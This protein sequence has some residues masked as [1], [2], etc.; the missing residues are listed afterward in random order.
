MTRTDEYRATLRALPDRDWDEYLCDRSGLPGPRGN[1]E[2][3]V[4]AAEEA[5][6]SRIRGW[7]EWDADRAPANTPAELLTFCGVLGLGRLVVEGDDQALVVLRRHASDPRWRTRE[8]V[9]MA[10]QRIADADF[11]RA[12]EIVSEWVRGG[13][14]ERRAAA[15]GL[16]EPRLLSSRDRT[17]AVLDLLDAIT[18]KVVSA[19]RDDRRHVDFRALRK[20]LGY[21]WSVAVASDPTTGTARM[22]RWIGVEDEDVRWLMRTN[23][24][25][26]RLERMD[27][28]WVA[29]QRSRLTWA[30]SSNP[31]AP[32]CG[33]VGTLGPFGPS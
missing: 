17:A 4:A 3:A 1:I 26:R 27:S 22:E 28:A 24:T 6:P 30:S 20:A 11:D 23:L 31:P 13:W 14:L 25:K 32:D 19:E 7:L 9:A 8:A 10:I 12:L 21:C 5:S 2:L 16:C 15:A 33:P 29:A 18:E